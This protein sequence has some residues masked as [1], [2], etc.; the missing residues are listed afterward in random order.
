MCLLAIFMSSLE[1][2]LFKSS[3]PFWI[4]LFFWYSATRVACILWRLILC[5]SLHVLLFSP[6]LR[7]AFSSCMVSV[8]VQEILSL[9]RSHLFISCF[10][11]ITLRGGVIEHLAVIYVKE[12]SAYVFL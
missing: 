3:A 8:V 4:R 11:S 6:I 7:A 5:Q 12:C 2:C 1:K 10:I 9:I